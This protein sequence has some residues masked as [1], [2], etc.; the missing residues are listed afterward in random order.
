MK[1]GRMKTTEQKLRYK[2]VQKSFVEE[3][4]YMMK[5]N[6][7]KKYSERGL[8]GIVSAAIDIKQTS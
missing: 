2:W 3:R 5:F 1:E 8:I 7:G 4:N 6:Q